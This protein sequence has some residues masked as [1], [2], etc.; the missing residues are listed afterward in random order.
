MFV[1]FVHFFQESF[2]VF[3][4]LQLSEG[5]VAIPDCSGE[6]QVYIAEKDEAAFLLQMCSR[7]RSSFSFYSITC[8]RNVA[9]ASYDLLLS[10]IA[11][12]VLD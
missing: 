3:L 5:R 4:I 9:T 2:I 7:Y 6:E 8:L 1:L 10:S 11:W 12:M